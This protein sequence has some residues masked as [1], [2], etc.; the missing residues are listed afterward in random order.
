MEDIFLRMDNFKDEPWYDDVVLYSRIGVC[1]PR[2]DNAKAVCKAL[3]ELGYK[4]QL[5]FRDGDLYVMPCGK[6][7]NAK[8]TEA[9]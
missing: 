9:R 8:E 4:V 3:R 2:P 7:K 1:K 5:K 6:F